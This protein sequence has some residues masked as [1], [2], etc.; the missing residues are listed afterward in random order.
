MTRYAFRNLRMIRL[1][2]LLLSF[3]SAIAVADPTAL[4]LPEPVSDRPIPAVLPAA[5]EY[6]SATT[7]RLAV[8][9]GEYRSASFLVVADQPLK[10]VVPQAEALQGDAGNVIPAEQFDIRIVKHW[11]QAA[12]GARTENLTPRLV[13][14]LLLKNDALVD[15][16]D[17]RNSLL[18]DT[19]K[20][21]DISKRG[22]SRQRGIIPVDQMPVRDSAEL[23]A[24]DIAAD[25][26]RQYWVTFAVP[27][28]AKPGVYRGVVAVRADDLSAEPVLELAIELEVL[29]FRLAPSMLT[30]S[31]FHKAKLD[32]RKKQ[33]S[34]SSELR[35]REQYRA[36]LDNILAHG[37]TRPNLY[38]KFGTPEFRGAMEIREAAGVDQ[39]ELFLIGL[40]A[41]PGS[42]TP[43][44]FSFL[45]DLRDAQK[46]VKRYGVEQLYVW[47]R[48]EAKA[49]RLLEQEAVWTAAR[50]GGAKIFAAGYHSTAATGKGNFELLGPLHDTFV[51]I[52]PVTREEA[53]RWHG[54]DKRIFSYQN[55]TGGMERPLTFRQNLGLFL[56]QMNYDGA[57]PYAYQDSF[58]NGWNDFDHAIY[59]DHNFVYPTVDG[60]IDT[61]QWEGL[62]EGVTDI[63][64]LSTLLAALNESSNEALNTEIR[65][66]LTELKETP[67]AR[68][69][70]DAIRA[71]FAGYILALQAGSGPAAE[72]SLQPSGL[73][74]TSGIGNAGRVEFETAD[75][76]AVTVR[77]GST[78]E[79]RDGQVRQSAL[80]RKHRVEL[81]GVKSN[82]PLYVQVV[83]G[84]A[85]APVESETVKVRDA[86][87]LSLAM[88]GERSDQSR[89]LTV[90][91]NAASQSH[92]ALDI[93]NTL[94]GWW[95]FSEG[96][97]ETSANLRGVAGDAEL[98]GDARWSKG[99]IGGGVELDGSGDFAYV[100][101]IETEAGSPVTIEAWVRFNQFALERGVRQGIFTGLYQHQVNNH[102][103]FNGKKALFEVSSLLRPNTWHHIVLTYQGTTASAVV[104]VDGQPVPVSAQRDDETLDPLDGFGAGR[105][106]SFFGGLLSGG[107]T[108]LDGSI[109]EVRVWNRI[110]SDAEVGL[111]FA[112]G[113]KRH[114]IDVTGSNSVTV[115]AVDADDA[116]VQTVVED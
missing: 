108:Q 7:L 46:L 103:Y 99:Y 16:A 61:L 113:A 98:E 104:Y 95:R 6:G 17:G 85:D 45:S 116:V 31:I 48:D 55:P 52:N 81:A 101:D 27:D 38:Q 10:Q 4:W 71:T 83:S 36:E 21:V 25:H 43:V 8:T 24:V 15:V 82:A 37:I 12:R 91:A 97:G 60:V 114:R 9:P 70:L 22:Q 11:Y 59:R 111:A 86:G 93:D 2:L 47:G 50:E 44:P 28:D 26:N 72:A 30:Y 29:P 77:Y 90:R 89:L 3:S 18:L 78:P 67:L 79:V 54:I 1:S 105:S 20:Y 40:P 65:G 84:T 92:A 110:L 42:T 109:D 75:R 88:A 112:A 62:R 100:S 87:G 115:L 5:A 32:D 80:V 53:A 19:G 73:R 23:Q 94:L 74:Y 57:M 58:G 35:S 66:W 13:P 96:E 68:M 63:R 76:S 14:E 102:F 39:R 34:V 33:G 49:E 69:D 64:Y 56:W 51:A 106:S 41:V 107:T